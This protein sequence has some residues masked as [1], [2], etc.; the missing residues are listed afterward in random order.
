MR[1]I[2]FTLLLGCSVSL[3]SATFIVTSNS[4]DATLSTTLPYA[5]VNSAAGDTINCT[6]IHGQTITLSKSLPAITHNLTITNAG[7]DAVIIS[8]A[9]AYQAFSI[10]SGT[11]VSITNFQSL[12]SVS[13]GGAGGSGFVGGGGGA[14][15]GGGLYVH[16]GTAVSIS[17]L[18]FT[19]NQAKGG[20]GGAG[21]AASGVGSGGGG[22]GFGGG[23]AG[24]VGGGGGGGSS[25]G[26]AGASGDVGSVGNGTFFGGGG[27]GS[28]LVTGGTSGLYSGGAG[29]TS[30][31]GG[32]AGAGGNGSA[33]SGTT[34]G[35]GGI[36]L[37]TDQLFG[38]GGGGAGGGSGMGTGGG[39]GD[40][41]GSFSLGG[42]GGALGGGGGGGAGAN[43]SGNGGLGAGGG[44]TGSGSATTSTFGGGAGGIGTGAGGGGGAGLGG[45]IF[46][47]SGGSVTIGN[48]VS[49]SGNTV[50]AGSGG[51]AAGSA[52]A[53]SAGTA[54]S[55]DIFL[56]SGASLIFNLTSAPLSLSSSIASNQ[57]TAVSSGG[58]TLTGSQILTLSNSSNTYTGGTNILS[59]T[60][61]VSSDGAL[62]NS[63]FGL[64]LGSGTLQAGAAFNTARTLALTGAG[65]LDTQG[66]NMTL[67]G[68]ISGG[69]SLAISNGGTITFS[70]AN[71]YSGGTTIGAGVTLQGSTTSLQNSI[72]HNGTNLIFNQTA[73]GT[74]SGSLSG[75]G[76]LTI[77]GTGTFYLSGS[78]P[79]FTG[80]VS[81]ATGME[82]NVDGSIANASTVTIPSGA[83]LSGSG[84]VGHV[85]NSGT[86]SPGNSIGTLTVNG[87][88]TLTG[89]SLLYIEIA[90]S[91][92]TD[93]IQVTGAPGTATLNGAVTFIPQTG[94]YGFGGDYTFV[95]S[96]GLGG[97]TFSSS[98][99]I[100][101]PIFNPTLSY[102]ANN[103]L[104]T[105]V[106]LRPFTDFP[107]INENTRNVGNNLDDLNAAG[108]LLTSLKDLIDSLA[109]QSF[110]TI[111]T[112]LDQMHPAPYSAFE[113][114]QAQVGGQ[115]VSLFHKKPYLQ[116]GCMRSQRL[117][118]EPFGNWLRQGNL[119]EQLGFEAITRGVAGG[120]DREIGSHW[121]LGIG[122]SYE[123]TDL[124]LLLGRGSGSS[125]GYYGAVYSDFGAD[126]FY[127]GLS[128]LAGKNQYHLSRH[129][130]FPSTAFEAT[131]RYH[132]FDMIGQLAMAYLLGSSSGFFYPYVNFD[133]LYMKSD[134]FH[135]EGTSPL[136]LDVRSHSSSTLRS[137]AG[138][139]LQ[140]QD[141]NYCETICI[142][143]LIALGW[144]ME[145]P[146][147]RP[148]Y[149]ANFAGEPISFKARGWNHTWQL[150][151]F[152][153]GLKLTYKRFALS[154]QYVGELSPEGRDEFF[155][156]RCN[157]RLDL[158][159]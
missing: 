67:S 93:L 95:T 83:T 16:T 31:G 53:G 81:L 84:T 105:V 1:F 41:A 33:A 5:I 155:G 127:L 45:A 3:H 78:S 80:A 15:G 29:S 129:I 62:G 4:D 58:L 109:G 68:V 28:V 149:Q 99:T 142:S 94:F 104:L 46:V 156:Q 153:F 107:F 20:S 139:A 17:S 18:T 69:G 66:F 157:I 9:S 55:N 48:S 143:P 72:A 114:L 10:A 36:G 137:E 132:S 82:L 60:L 154:G 115:L 118:A 6:A 32:G 106:I 113:D 103:A 56:V 123:E 52:S 96:S 126:N 14:G 2:D 158:N 39:G 25:G 37:G 100:S 117:W 124:T 22:G 7:A 128:F 91:G 98:P 77:Q 150:F 63:S 120:F 141:A 19:T 26:G 112:E 122:G 108:E 119:G 87:T 30:A 147:R 54:L 151:S 79:S 59:G 88:L 146:L 13:Q 111:N 70:G 130:Q 145:C 51:T 42:A 92:V 61:A 47:Q 73:D 64:S 133:F 97:S 50:T 21:T 27:G 134:A 131:G 125:H 35:A 71:T 135:E 76:P 38:G 74:Y 43:T 89:S 65:T 86:I 136:N 110:A 11:N 75:A 101:N 138:L 121:V 90:P 34:G 12:N 8:G 159:W 40:I 57:N 49:F 144:V 85:A 102:T 140:V 24:A 44:G 116:C 148:Y 23:A 152:N